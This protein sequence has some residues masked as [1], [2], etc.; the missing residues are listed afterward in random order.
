MADDDKARRKR[1]KSLKSQQEL[2]DKQKSQ[3]IR[4]RA[5]RKAREKLINEGWQPPVR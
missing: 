3:L 5:E 1:A 4:L 2:I